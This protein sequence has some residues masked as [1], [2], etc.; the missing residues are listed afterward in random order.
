MLWGVLNFIITYTEKNPVVRFGQQICCCSWEGD[1]F[2]ERSVFHPALMICHRAQGLMKAGEA[3]HIC[4]AVHVARWTTPL[5]KSVGAARRLAERWRSR[6]AGVCVCCSDRGIS[7]T[8]TLLPGL[9]ALSSA[10]LQPSSVFVCVCVFQRPRHRWVWLRR[11]GGCSQG[12]VR[13][14]RGHAKKKKKNNDLA[15]YLW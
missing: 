9:M 10:D 1:V 13:R 7:Q 2:G 8:F 4:P 12:R 11:R 3:R 15:K 14:S 6:W 5:V